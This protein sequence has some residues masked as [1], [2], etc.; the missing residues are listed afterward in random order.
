MNATFDA[1]MSEKWWFLFF[2][3][4]KTLDS[5]KCYRLKKH[6]TAY[7]TALL[8]WAFVKA[9]IWVGGGQNDKAESSRGLQS[10]QTPHQEDT[11]LMKS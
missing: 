10:S 5:S 4:N 9:Y 2:F 11:I 8:N 7:G 6:I 1:F 3:C